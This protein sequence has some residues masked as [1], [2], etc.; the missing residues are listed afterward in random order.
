M[1]GQFGMIWGW[2]RYGAKWIDLKGGKNQQDFMIDWFLVCVVVQM[3][4]IFIDIEYIGRGSYIM[5]E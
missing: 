5:V 4:I 3:L 1:S 2:G